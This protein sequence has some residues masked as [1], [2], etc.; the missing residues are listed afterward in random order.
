MSSIDE[1]LSDFIT[2][3][4]RGRR[5]EVLDALG[6]VPEGPERD[7]LAEQLEA[8]LLIAP[9]PALDDSQRAEIRASPAVQ[10]AFAA[11]D[12]P[13]G[14]WPQVLPGLRVRAGLSVSELASRM[15]AKVGLAAGQDERAADYLQRLERGEL[16]ADGLSRRLIRAL[17]DALEI[18]QEGLADLGGAFAARPAPAPGIAFRAAPG[19]ADA[20][21]EGQIHRR[22]LEAL[23]PAAA[24]QDELDRLFCGGPDA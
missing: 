17:G 19:Q 1:I 15:L 22:S 10:A 9:A 7:E 4:N 20:W 14:A 24:A 13:A 3:W 12:H 21:L 8:F 2:D 23:E 11:V 16:R 6:R 18:G 5:P